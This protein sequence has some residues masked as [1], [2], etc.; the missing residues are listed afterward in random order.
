MGELAPRS[1]HDL[2]QDA[3]SDPADLQRIARD[4]PSDVEIG[5]LLARNPHTSP[6]TLEFLLHHAPDQVVD[7]IRRERQGL[8]PIQA[9]EKALP[10]PSQQS[11]TGGPETVLGMI[12]R[13]TVPEKVR[14]ALRADKEARSILVRDPNR[15]VSQAVLD[16]PRLTEQEVVL[17]AQSRNVSDEVLRKI[18]LKK[19]WMGKSEVVSAIVTNPR[20]PLQVALTHLPRLRALELMRVSR[21][22]SVPE[23][24]QKAAAK[25][26]KNQNR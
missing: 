1:I 14:F 8:A 24:L 2:A 12:Q 11:P 15:L 4:H 25:L 10:P 22:H 17:I 7:C 13:M 3:A 18:A 26:L 20:T 16:S 5:L 23:A 19:E 21:S 9:L 6:E